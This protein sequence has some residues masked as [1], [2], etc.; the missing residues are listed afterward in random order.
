MS[1]D[2][3]ADRCPEPHGHGVPNHPADPLETV[4]GIRF[5]ELVSLG[6]RLEDRTLT[7]RK[8]SVLFRMPEATVAETVELR[9]DGRRRFVPLHTTVHTRIVLA[10]LF[11]M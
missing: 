5:H 6:K 10:A 7:Q 1:D 2:S 3:F 9:R 4:V 11:F 8:T